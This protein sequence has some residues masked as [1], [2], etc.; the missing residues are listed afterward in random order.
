[1]ENENYWWKGQKKTYRKKAKSAS[2]ESLESHSSFLAGSTD[3]KKEG[4]SQE[5]L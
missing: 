1:L 5:T 2:G 4:G 3:Q